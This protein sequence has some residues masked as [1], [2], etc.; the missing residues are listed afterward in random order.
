MEVF[1]RWNN[2]SK[3]IKKGKR[4]P[5]E[6]ARILR[7]IQDD[8]DFARKLSLAA[9]PSLDIQLRDWQKFYVENF[10]L[11]KNFSKLRIPKRKK[12]LNRLIVVVK[13]LTLNR[14]FRHL[15]H[16][17]PA[18]KYRDFNQ[19]R[20]V[21]EFDHD[22]AIWVRDRVE[23]DEELKS[24]SANS[25]EKEGINGITLSEHLLYVLKYYAETKNH[26]DVQNVTLCSGSHFSD[27]G[28]PTV[29]LGYDQVRI[30]QCKPSRAHF[31]LRS[32]EVIS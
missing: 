24:R 13:C 27:G 1:E 7:F 15:K 26:L 5:E 21:R 3:L 28:V 12:G 11:K 31:R 8:P 25:I 14:I 2:I 6:V 19:V 10:D 22:Y 16:L 18:W 9:M 4:N 20:S 23:A 30:N 17:M 29:R 32:R